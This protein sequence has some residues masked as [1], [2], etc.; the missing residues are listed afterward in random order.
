MKSEQHDQ[1]FQ[2]QRD[3]D[4]RKIIAEHVGRLFLGNGSCVRVVFTPKGLCLSVDKRA[5]DEGFIFVSNF[6]SEIEF[7]GLGKLY[8]KG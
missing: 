5:I 6:E 1:C 7:A 3:F 2:F 8:D 4:T